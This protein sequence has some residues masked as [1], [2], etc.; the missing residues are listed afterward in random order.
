MVMMQKLSASAK[1]LG[2]AMKPIRI[3]TQSN[4]VK[5]EYVAAAT[6]FRIGEKVFPNAASDEE[7]VI[8]GSQIFKTLP[9]LSEKISQGLGRACCYSQARQ[10]HLMRNNSQPFI[11]QLLGL[12]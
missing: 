5:L 7:A 3:A 8:C 10:I 12:I 9:S 11:T 1:A 4:K 6:R 2:I